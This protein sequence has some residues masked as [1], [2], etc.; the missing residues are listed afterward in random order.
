MN[1]YINLLLI[2]ERQDTMDYKSSHKNDEYFWK[3]NFEEFKK[4]DVKKYDKGIMSYNFNRN[5]YDKLIIDLL[6]PIL[7]T[8]P[9]SGKILDAGGG[10]GKWTVYFAKKGFH[11]HLIDI[12][13]SMLDFA[14]D[15]INDLQLNNNVTILHGSICSLPF[16]NQAFDFVFSERNPVSHC[17]KREA[18]YKAV[19]ELYRVLKPTCFLWACV[20]N[21]IRKVAQL[22]M[23]LDFKRA[24]ELLK[25]GTM[26]R[27]QNEYTY[28][29]LENELTELLANTGFRDIQIY[30]TTAM[31]ELIPSAWLLG[32]EP[33]EEL[34]KIE[35]K[36]YCMPEARNYGVRL[37]AIAKK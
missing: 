12:S 23:E 8:I 14:S 21:R 1:A 18:S 28:Y 35:K 15:R 32:D 34:L 22:V 19:M 30:P 33:I 4:K 11:V 5:L 36:V 25:S 10:T 29:Y 24:Q 9:H 3:E 27:S 17:G 13:K 6:D 16:E 2:K 20:L 37:H 7:D 26:A 31:A